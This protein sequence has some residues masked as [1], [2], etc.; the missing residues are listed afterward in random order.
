MSERGRNGLCLNLFNIDLNRYRRFL[1]PKL[2]NNN[3]LFYQLLSIINGY[4]QFKAHLTN[5]QISLVNKINSCEVKFFEVV[6]K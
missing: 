3:L 4:L 6:Q 1:M 2:E 5:S